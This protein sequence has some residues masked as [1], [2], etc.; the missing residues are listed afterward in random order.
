MDDKVLTPESVDLLVCN[1][2]SA[3]EE[4]VARA[5]TSAELGP[6]EAWDLAEDFIMRLVA[7]PHCSLR[8]R[9]WAFLNNFEQAFGRL[10]AAEADCRRAGELLRGSARVEKLLATILAVGN[11]LNG[12]TPRGRADG[13]DIDT[14]AKLQELKA[15]RQG[16]L[17]DFIVGEVERDCPGML[18]EL[19]APGGESCAVQRAR[20]HRIMEAADELTGLIAQAE[21]FG[22]VLNKGVLEGPLTERARKLESRLERLYELRRSFDAWVPFYDT[23]CAWFRMEPQKQR[24]PDEFFGLWAGFFGGVA[25]SLAALE[26]SRRPRPCAG[27]RRAASARPAGTGR[28]GTPS[29]GRAGSSRGSSGGRRLRPPRRVV[30]EASEGSRPPLPL[31]PM[32][33][34]APSEPVPPLGLS[35]LTEAAAVP[36]ASPRSSPRRPARSRPPS[37]LSSGSGGCDTVQATDCA[38]RRPDL[39]LA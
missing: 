28:L 1:L 30:G 35:A 32:E 13:F 22:A 18:G 2:P 19:L 27:S 26:E 23:L 16:T 31:P 21:G 24:P 12:G 34:T 25:R 39:P 36:R 8:L 29:P 4:D 7:I 14:L 17:L 20:G 38:H 5:A 3:A 6:N 10:A 33:T 37:R 11:Y 9:L 15:M